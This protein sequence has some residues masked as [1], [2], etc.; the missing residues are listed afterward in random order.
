ML[1][2]RETWSPSAE[3]PVPCNDASGV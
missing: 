1:S 3:D 2:R